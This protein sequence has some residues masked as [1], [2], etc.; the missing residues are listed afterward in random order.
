MVP[1]VAVD[2]PLSASVPARPVELWLLRPGPANTVSGVQA[3]SADLVLYAPEGEPA[4]EPQAA[5][6]AA[7]LAGDAPRT[8]DTALAPR[9][10]NEDDQALAVRVFA[11]VHAAVRGA[12]PGTRVIVVVELDVLR[13][14]VAAALGIPPGR[15]GALLVEPGRAVMLRDDPLGFVLRRANVRAPEREDESGDAMPV[16]KGAGQKNA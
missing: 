3:T 9:R 14:I 1:C 12:R 15:H 2:S 8:L 11:P 4:G 16:W 7:A 10:T 5:R 6:W 13:A